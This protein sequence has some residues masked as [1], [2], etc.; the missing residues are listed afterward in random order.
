M[1]DALLDAAGHYFWLL[2]PMKDSDITRYEHFR[3]IAKQ[4]GEEP[5]ELHG[6]GMPDIVSHIWEWFQEL[7]ASRTAGAISYS[8]IR[9]WAKLTG[10]DPTPTEIMIIKELDFQYLTQLQDG[11]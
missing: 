1:I 2:A 9:A 10:R 5:D 4:T 8:E 6:P 7:H 3:G 11:R